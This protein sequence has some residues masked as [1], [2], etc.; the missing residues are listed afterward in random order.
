MFGIKRQ[1]PARTYEQKQGE[2]FTLTPEV[3]D[4]ARAVSEAIGTDLFG[5]DIVISRG[6]PYVVDV[7]P[8]PGFKGVPDGALRL[9]EY[10][11]A[12]AAATTTSAVE[13]K[14]AGPAVARRAVGS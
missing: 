13:A 10:I 5:L 14:D 9:A 1:W 4:I 8:F 12:K 3:H 2:Q 6:Q 11:Y 7:N